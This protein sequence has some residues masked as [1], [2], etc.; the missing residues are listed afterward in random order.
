M[1]LSLLLYSPPAQ[2]PAK[3]KH[4][5]ARTNHKQDA[6]AALP[7]P[8]PGALRIP[9]YVAGRS[10][11]PGIAKPI[12]LSS[13]ESALGSSPKAVAAYQEAAANLHRYPDSGAT[14]LRAAIAARHG[15]A[16]ANIVCGDGSDEI[17]HLLGLGYA[18]A[19]DEVL[20]TG[21][22][23]V[24]YPMVAHAVGATPVAAPERECT[25]D[26]DALLAKVTARTKIVFVAN[27]NS[28]GTYISTAE[29]ARL[30]AGLSADVLLVLD[31]AYAEYV[32]AADYT[33]GDQFVAAGNT[34]VTRTFSKA[35]G[36]AGLR[37]GWCNCPGAVA[38]VLNRLRAPFNV[39]VPAQ[40]AGVAAVGDQD[41][42]ATIRA[43][44]SQWRP[45]LVQQLRGFGLHP[46]P[47]VTNFVLVRFPGGAAQADG[48][49]AFLTARGILVRDMKAYGLGECLR[50]TVGREDELRAMV[51]SLGEFLGPA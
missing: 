23:F 8:R 1:R 20:Y 16:A 30:R 39:T 43:H 41:F 38:D 6:S 35:Y 51:Q 36:L 34:V 22:G 47:S 9:P 12:K 50:I 11:V 42:L 2:A 21:H 19:G 44:N 45:W 31:A 24:V 4:M 40:A 33:A 49:N 26:V 13:N 46:F 3:S 17:L 14:A 48:A 29:V 15:V 32:D 18:G 37:L 7:Q 25:V 28:T 27:P 5:S 10:S